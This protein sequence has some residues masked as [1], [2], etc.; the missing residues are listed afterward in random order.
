MS[1]VFLP[2]PRF[3]PYKFDIFSL[4][5]LDSNSSHSL[6]YSLNLAVLVIF[7]FLLTPPPMV[8]HYQHKLFLLE[9]LNSDHCLYCEK[10]VFC[11]LIW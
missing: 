5:F 7:L 3:L 9:V 8:F 2:S 4:L 11:C 10:K 1:N 6:L